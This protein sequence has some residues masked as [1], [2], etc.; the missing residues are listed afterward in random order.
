MI[1]TTQAFAPT[2]DNPDL[3]MEAIKIMWGQ[4]ILSV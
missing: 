4:S 1:L 2:F 3:E